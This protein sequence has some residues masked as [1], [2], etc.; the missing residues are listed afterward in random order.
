MLNLR[1]AVGSGDDRRGREGDGYA[2]VDHV[3]VSA[4]RLW[5]EAVADGHLPW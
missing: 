1:H 5:M 3:E 4:E 2:G